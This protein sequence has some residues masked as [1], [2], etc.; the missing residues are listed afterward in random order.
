MVS[1]EYILATA[2]FELQVWIA[3]QEY[4]LTKF[5]YV[6]RSSMY[7]YILYY[8][9]VSMFHI[10]LKQR[11]RAGEPNGIWSSFFSS[12]PR[13]DRGQFL[14][15]AWS[16]WSNGL[17]QHLSGMQCPDQCRCMSRCRMF[18]VNASFGIIFSTLVRVAVR[19]AGCVC[20]CYACCSTTLP[21]REEPRPESEGRLASVWCRTRWSE[22]TAW[23]AGPTRFN[24]CRFCWVVRFG[25]PTNEQSS[26]SVSQQPFLG[27]WGKK[28]SR[29]DQRFTLAKETIC[30]LV[31]KLQSIGYNI[32]IYISMHFTATTYTPVLEH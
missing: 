1:E 2:R 20:I 16:T 31:V 3:H 32:Y 25:D 23:S 26:Q 28:T 30:P 29:N 21:A 8:S 9:V 11:Q 12:E 19:L 14:L 22:M 13:C 7:I 18:G 24:G 5:R 27:I 10:M 6:C 15:C 17:S 4:I